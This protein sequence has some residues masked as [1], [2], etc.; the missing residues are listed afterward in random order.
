MT[1]DYYALLT[2]VPQQLS[3]DDLKCLVFSCGSIR[4]PSSVEKIA[5]GIDLF[6]EL[7]QRGHLGPANYDY[8]R[9]QLV[10]V[11]RHDLASML[12]DKIEVLY[13]QSHIRD[14]R[15][16]G[17]VVSPSAPVFNP[18]NVSTLKFCHPNAES[19]MFL[20]LLSQ[21]LNSEDSRKLAFL[22]YPTP[23][24]T[25]AMELAELLESEGGLYS[26]AIVNRLSL[27]LEAVGRVDLA[28][29]VNSLKAPQI[30]LNALS[31]SHQQLNLK[32]S[33]LL[34]SKQ[35]SY[36][37]YMRA[38]SEVEYDNEV[39]VKLLGP[40]TERVKEYFDPS[41]ICSLAKN[42][43]TA[44]QDRVTT[45]SHNN[46]TDSL[47]K[48]S[49]LESLKVNQAFVRR[50]TIL[51][52][53]K[54]LPVEKLYDLTEQ[55]RESYESF[56]S[57]MDVLKWN[58]VVRDELRETVKLHQ[59]PFGTPA[60]CA[61]QYILELT[62][63]LSR[64]DKLG[65]A[66]QKTGQH[67]V[68]LNNNYYS[69]C[70][71]LVTLQWLASLLYFSTSFD[72]KLLDLCKHVDTLRYIIQQ[73]KDEILKLYSNIAEIVGSAVL[74]KLV[75]LQHLQSTEESSIQPETNPFVLLFNVLIIKLLAFITL[76]RES[77]D[78]DDVN[79][80]QVDHKFCNRVLH[81]TSPII[82][83]SA[84]AMKKEVEAFRKKTLSEDFLCRH[85]I[86]MLTQ[87]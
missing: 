67:L 76:D 22:M 32:M 39:R 23:S 53:C 51:E 42:V 2:S 48:A 9:K 70:Y 62:Q 10:L 30:L 38:L 80:M 5:S 44:M 17:C 8:L 26:V 28:M 19:R 79:F 29:L 68:V 55:L 85:V 66:M 87:S 35:Q 40:V 20:M 72:S 57:L 11:G 86:A 4:P 69:C 54:Q 81:I 16:F 59:S 82:R 18:L 33:L 37:F 12:P 50:L 60:E 27:C 15:H 58:S 49:L 65:Q 6:L 7:K 36:D 71:H 73:K 46:D 25:S 83:I 56:S 31:T 43:Q 41:Q 52:S 14:K 77:L 78:V 64:C 45:L 13:G 61:C 47:I 24:H 84:S 21:Q 3:K 63:E 34:H 1:S 75:P 74:Q